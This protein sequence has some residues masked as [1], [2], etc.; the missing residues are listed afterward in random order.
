MSPRPLLAQCGLAALLRLTA[1]DSSAANSSSSRADLLPGFRTPRFVRPMVDPDTPADARK[2]TDHNGDGFELVFSDE[3]NT[4]GRSFG[5]GADPYW[6]AVDHFNPTTSDLEYYSSEQVTT[7]GGNLVITATM[8]PNEGHPYTSG[9]LT[10]WNQ[11]CFTVSAP[12]AASCQRASA[13]SSVSAPWVC[14]RVA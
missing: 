2:T 13:I 10:S 14:C 8:E 9:M 5:P 3:F 1:S 11:M 7:V 12:R 6:T 4:A